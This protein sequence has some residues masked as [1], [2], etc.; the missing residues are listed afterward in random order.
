MKTHGAIMRAAA[1]VLLLMLFLFLPAGVSAS[2]EDAHTNVLVYMIG[3]DLESHDKAATENIHEMLAAAKSFGDEVSLL[4]YAGGTQRWHNDIFSAEENRCIRIDRNGTELLYSEST[5]SMTDPATLADFIRYCEKHCP[6][7]RNILIFWNHGSGFLGF[8]ADELNDFNDPMSIP[9]IT[10]ALSQGGMHFS[11]IGFDACM[12]ASAELAYCLADY[13]DYMVASEEMEPL[14]GWDYAEWLSALAKEPGTGDT[15]ICKIIADTY[16]D[17]C[18]HNAPGI[19]DTLSVID[20]K[21]FSATVPQALSS[22]SA[23]M[24]DNLLAGEYDIISVQ[25]VLTTNVCKANRVNMI[26]AITLAGSVKNWEAKD[27]EHAL[28]ESVVYNR[29]YPADLEMNG[30]MLRIPEKTDTILGESVD[31]IERLRELGISESYLDWITC[32]R[33]YS[34]YAKGEKQQERTLSDILKN[35]GSNKYDEAIYDMISKTKLD[36]TGCCVTEDQNLT[37]ALVMPEE[38]KQLVLYISQEVYRYIGGGLKSR[39]EIE[40]DASDY[41]IIDYGGLFFR[42]EDFPIQYSSYFWGSMCDSCLYINDVLCPFYMEEKTMQEDGKTM[43]YGYTK[44]CRNGDEGVLYLRLVYDNG[45]DSVHVEPLCYQEVDFVSFEPILGRIIPVAGIAADDEV[46][47]CCTRYTS[48]AGNALMS[49]LTGDMRWGD[50]AA[51]E[52]KHTTE[53]DELQT[54]YAAIDL[55][56]NMHNLELK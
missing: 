35:T 31:N 51:I 1:A 37:P 49:R 55:Y 22:F 48:G 20:L 6:A 46:Y 36:V 30:I 2:A 23:R 29:K 21:K 33:K 38:K 7:G 26:D 53:V 28:R 24:L 15:A 42:P 11:I 19:K 9:E 14:N 40:Y 12:M 52:W 5:R 56:G 34:D 10:A 45:N 8:G 41:E 3:S 39:M 47:F 27:L 32:Y 17:W 54:A 44:M 16:M 13:G 18:K 43:V 25:K 50:I 4:V